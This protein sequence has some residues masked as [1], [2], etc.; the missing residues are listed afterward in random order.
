MT[1]RDHLVQFYFAEPGDLG[2]ADVR[3]A[4]TEAEVSSWASSRLQHLQIAR[5]RP[6]N[7]APRSSRVLAPDGR[8]VAELGPVG[9]WHTLAHQ[10]SG[11]DSD[12][13]C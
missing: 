2:I 5:R 11:A 12:T 3:F 13:R 9:G 6:D 8:V 4:G 1:V 7:L 10:S